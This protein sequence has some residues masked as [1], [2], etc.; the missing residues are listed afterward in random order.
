VNSTR[1]LSGAQ[2]S[3]AL[4]PEELSRE[5]PRA[6]P[7]LR[8]SFRL[9]ASSPPRAKV[10]AAS[11][12]GAWS[13][14]TFPVSTAAAAPMAREGAPLEALER[15][16]NTFRLLRAR[17]YRAKAA[18]ARV[19]LRQLRDLYARWL[20]VGVSDFAAIT[21]QTREMESRA[22]WHD[23]RAGAQLPRFDA[24]RGCGSA[25]LHIACKVCAEGLCAPVPCTCGVVRVCD[26]CAVAV[27]AKRQKRI[28]AARVEAMAEGGTRRLFDGS[29]W[30]GAFSEKMLTL[31]VP[32]FERAD[33]SGLVIAETQGFGLDNTVSARLAA[34]RLAWPRFM[35]RVR[36]WLRGRGRA[37]DRRWGDPDDASAFAYYRLLEWTRGHDGK[38]H[39]HFHVY[40]FSPWLP[41]S[42]GLLRQWWAEALAA[43]GVPLPRSCALCRAGSED[44]RVGLGGAHV[45]IDLK[46]LDGFNWAALK[47][48]VKSGDR[49]AIEARMG[50]LRT[51]A[52]PGLDAIEYA[53]AWTMSDAFARAS[54]LD[55]LPDAATLDVQRDLYC[56]LE[57]RRLAQGS[58]GFLLAPPVPACGL[59]GASSFT[60]GVVYAFDVCQET[61]A[62][63]P[64][65]ER[66]PPSWVSAALDGVPAA[67]SATAKGEVYL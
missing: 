66:G 13:S 50:T 30:G 25:S 31:T 45:I 64:R 59:C 5:V 23:R 17:D 16:T 22:K 62:D 65:E 29:R 58:R 52:A 14:A 12:D 2:A 38:G 40:L 35:R 57:G 15:A 41:A 26:A 28:A 21:K 48:L 27:A 39:P 63:V 51:H 19:V 54:L 9:A 43:V 3:S 20:T 37:A 6:F 49:R 46:S 24:V 67:A 53:A 8:R 36:T 32:H 44:C 18:R 56:A 10:L 1:A 7:A 42:N 61:A 47:E 60:A 55:E 4:T 34:L 33:A 11:G